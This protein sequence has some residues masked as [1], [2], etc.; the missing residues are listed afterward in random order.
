MPSTEA[1]SHSVRVLAICGSLQSHSANLELL[2][3]AERLA[4]TNLTLTIF[5]GLRTLP[6]FNPDLE[7]A[8]PPETVHVWRAAIV[9]CD[10]LLIAS[11]EYGH[12]LP[13]A[14]KNAIDWVIGSGELEQ[15]V[16]AVTCAVPELSRGTK[17]LAALCETL[18][19]V[20]AQVVGGIP[21]ARGPGF[22]GEVSALL[23][24]LVVAVDVR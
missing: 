16:V 21:I 20:R 17:G 9:M 12:S 5:D 10:A 3:V 24:A 11:P 1:S 7:S 18:G 4:P 15:K 19:A 22:E 14:L 8:A 13:G 2:R 23:R 6:H